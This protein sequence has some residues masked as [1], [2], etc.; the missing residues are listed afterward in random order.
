M[1]E[2]NDIDYK[3]AKKL[4]YPAN[5][6]GLYQDDDGNPIHYKKV[7]TEKPYMHHREILKFNCWWI[8]KEMLDEIKE[9]IING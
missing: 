7:P 8:P 2:G 6:Y 3:L 9:R 4:G 5:G 1:D